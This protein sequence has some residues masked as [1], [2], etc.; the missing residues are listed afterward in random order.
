MEDYRGNYQA[1][2]NRGRK[3]CVSFARVYVIFLTDFPLNLRL[4]YS[5]FI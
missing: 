4:K 5:L 1:E 2:L 3:Y